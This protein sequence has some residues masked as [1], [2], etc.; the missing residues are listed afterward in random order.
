MGHAIPKIPEVTG[1]G[2]IV[3]GEVLRHKIAKTWADCSL[4]ATIW[5]P[6]ARQG[7]EGGHHAKE[8]KKCRLVPEHLL[9][10]SKVNLVEPSNG[11]S[12]S[13]VHLIP[14]NTLPADD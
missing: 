14:P 6:V 8:A 10:T 11:T 7:I 1:E 4:S 3:I 5:I 9:D 2:S 12:N 13:R